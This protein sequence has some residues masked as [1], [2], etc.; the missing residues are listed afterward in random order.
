V[1]YEGDDIPYAS[2][3]N[4]AFIFQFY[5]NIMRLVQIISVEICQT[6]LP[7]N[8]SELRRLLRGKKNEVAWDWRKNIDRSLVISINF[9]NNIFRVITS[10]TRMGMVV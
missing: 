3:N 8:I 5:V 10:R 4:F 1:G 2:I 9:T 7:T 6:F